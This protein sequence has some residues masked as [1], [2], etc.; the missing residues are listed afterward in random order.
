MFGLMLG[1]RALS[2]VL[3]VAALAWAFALMPVTDASAGIIGR[4]C[5]S[6]NPSTRCIGLRKYLYGVGGTK[7]D[8]GY[9]QQFD[10]PC[11]GAKTQSDG[12]GGNAIPF[13]CP[14]LTWNEAR[15]T[16]GGQSNWGYPTIINNSPYWMAVE[17]DMNYSN[18]G[19]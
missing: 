1:R 16:P 19:P 2:V 6:V 13:I 11:I 9:G 12:S 14:T 17:G 5:D 8:V 18:T 15:W 7:W 3:A 10:T 4:F